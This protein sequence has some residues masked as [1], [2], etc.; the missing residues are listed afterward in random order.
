MRIA[1]GWVLDHQMPM[2]V[3]TVLT[4]LIRD[5]SIRWF[6]KASFRSRPN[7]GCIS[8][9]TGFTVIASSWP[10]NIR[11]AMQRIVASLF[12]RSSPD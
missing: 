6:R 1:L 10:V 5:T 9:L 4:A 7:G 11:K 3:A 2:L 12:T 8:A